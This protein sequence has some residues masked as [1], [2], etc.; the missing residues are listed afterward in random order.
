M[1]ERMKFNKD[2]VQE[3]KLGAFT[4]KTDLGANTRKYCFSFLGKLINNDYFN[5]T[6][7]IEPVI[8]QLDDTE[9]TVRFC[10]FK[11]LNHLAHK[12]MSGIVDKLELMLKK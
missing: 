9:E 1:A 11:I 2:L 3:D 4:L 6:P 10:A 12:G 5:A 7:F 8:S